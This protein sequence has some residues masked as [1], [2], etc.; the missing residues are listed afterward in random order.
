M[1]L[2]PQ[3]FWMPH[4]EHAWNW[5]AERDALIIIPK[6]TGPPCSNKSPECTS[7]IKDTSASE[8]FN[9]FQ[10]HWLHSLWSFLGIYN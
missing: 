9:I 7:Y 2:W 6:P 1:L 4:R 5:E 3:L 10:E 8:G